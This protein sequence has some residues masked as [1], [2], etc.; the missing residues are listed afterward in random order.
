MRTLPKRLTE[1]KLAL[2]TGQSYEPTRVV[3]FRAALR[4]GIQASD[5]YG[6]PRNHGTCGIGGLPLNRTGSLALTECAN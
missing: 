3:R 4:S 5:R 1:W 2:R 6:R